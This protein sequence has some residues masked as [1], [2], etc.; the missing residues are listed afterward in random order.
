MV[1]FLKTIVSFASLLFGLGCNGSL[2]GREGVVVAPANVTGG[3]REA[4]IRDVMS[5]IVRLGDVVNRLRADRMRAGA[6]LAELAPSPEFPQVERILGIML[7]EL[8]RA[9]AAGNL[10][11]EFRT[12]EVYPIVMTACDIDDGELF[13]ALWEYGMRETKRE[14]FLASRILSKR[15]VW[16][17]GW[18]GSNR[19][20]SFAVVYD[21]LARELI[22]A[23]PKAGAP[24]PAPEGEALFFRTAD[25]AVGFWTWLPWSDVPEDRVT[26]LAVTL[27]RLTYLQRRVYH[28]RDEQAATEA[29][30][31]LAELAT[32]QSWLIGGLVFRAMYT[33]YLYDPRIL[34]LLE[35]HGHPFVKSRTEGPRVARRA[36]GL[37]LD[38]SIPVSESRM[39]N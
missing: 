2:S 12:D 16:R 4:E 34:A 23:R 11:D 30:D 15:D 19:G 26:D 35:Q 17:E 6:K 38:K 13:A 22:P 24:P 29:R 33:D 20:H 37:P 18:K 25:G 8:V 7:D 21:A 5:D 28:L 3:F 36:H 14:G 9:G 1:S 10:K 27:E 32:E 31:L 39:I